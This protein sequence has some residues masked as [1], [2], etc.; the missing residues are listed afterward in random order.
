MERQVPF[1]IKF[2]TTF[3]ERPDVSLI[4]EPDLARVCAEGLRTLLANRM[5]EINE[6]ATS[7]FVE[8]S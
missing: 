5:V 6:G 3:K 7:I 1:T 4:P 2:V 8:M